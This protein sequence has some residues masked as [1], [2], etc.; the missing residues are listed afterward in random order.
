MEVPWHS[1]SVKVLLAVRR[2]P[3]LSGRI[4]ATQ[5]FLQIRQ[6]SYQI[7]A[8]SSHFGSIDRLAT[9][10]KICIRD[11]NCR[12][13]GYLSLPGATSTTW[14]PGCHRT[15]WPGSASPPVRGQAGEIDRGSGIHRER[16]HAGSQ[17]GVVAPVDGKSANSSTQQRGALGP[18][19][20]RTQALLHPSEG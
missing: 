7:W 19:S 3:R 8:S 6:A 5:I 14:E 13:N 18:P 9:T 2:D 10:A 1:R 11:R 17:P 15:A 12:A 4:R 16:H 20:L